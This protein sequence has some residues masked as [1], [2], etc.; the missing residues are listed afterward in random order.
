MASP[1]E[2]LLPPPT[3]VNDDHKVYSFG[4]A[5]I[6]MGIVGSSSVLSRLFIRYRHGSLG[7]DDYAMISALVLFLSWMTMAS[8]LCLNAGVGKPLWEITIHEYSMWLQG[9]MAS[10]WLYPAMSGSI[11]TSILLFYLRIFGQGDKRSRDIIR[12]LLVLQGIYIVAFSITPAFVCRDFNQTSPFVWRDYCS[13]GYFTIIQTTLYSVSLAF[14]LILMAF[15][16][17]PLWKVQLDRAKKIKAIAIFIVGAAASVVAAYKLGVSIVEWVHVVPPDSPFWKYQ[18]SLYVPG[19]YDSYGR[20]FWIPATCEP[21]IALVGTSLPAFRQLV[22]SIKERYYKGMSFR[23]ESS[24]IYVNSNGEQTKLVDSQ[25]SSRR[26]QFVMLR[27][28]NIE[29]QEQGGSQRDW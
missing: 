12:A 28:S 3:T 17:Y 25:T 8:Y 29:L 18:L 27:D 24:G 6:V 9:Q 15:P 13:L 22:S 5:C 19:Q 14:D 16:A 7:M 21:T 4:V 26:G 1:V 23:T 11:R 20:T 2:K 10:I